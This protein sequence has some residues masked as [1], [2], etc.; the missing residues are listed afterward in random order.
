MIHVHDGQCGKCA[1]FG[2]DHPQDQKIV[3]IRISGQADEEL[4][5]SCGHPKNADLHL[6]VT[7]ISGCDGFT[8]AKV[9]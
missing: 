9:A 5:E 2:E 3:Q 1:H 4:V 8:P 6:K 7:P